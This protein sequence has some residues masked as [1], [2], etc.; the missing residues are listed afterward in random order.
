MRPIR[1]RLGFLLSFAAAG[2]AA[3]GAQTSTGAPPQQGDEGFRFKSGVELVNGTATVSDQDGHFVSGLTKDDFTVYEAGQRKA[4]T[5]SSN[6]RVQH[7][8]GILL[9]TRGRK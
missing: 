8:L 6:E 5:N 2:V 9:S 7:T 4:F 1:L 3:V